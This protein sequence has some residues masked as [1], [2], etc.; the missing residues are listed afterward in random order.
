MCTINFI[1][2]RMRFEPYLNRGAALAAPLCSLLDDSFIIHSYRK[3]AGVP[4][5]RAD[6]ASAHRSF[7]GASDAQV[8][9]DANSAN[10]P[11]SPI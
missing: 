7:S 8:A 6:L 2:R 1:H 10:R 9:W 5:R 3:R 4:R 11:V